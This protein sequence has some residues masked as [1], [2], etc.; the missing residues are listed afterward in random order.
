MLNEEQAEQSSTVAAYGGANAVTHLQAAALGARQF[1]GL[2]RLYPFDT[3]TPEGR[4]RERHRRVVLSAS[5]AAT[6]KF[7]SVATALISVP[8]T[9]HYLGPER[10][11]MWMTMSSLI[12]MFA[13][14]DLG[15]GHGILNVVA[16]A[17]GREDRNAI[18]EAASSGFFVL[19]I[20]AATILVLFAAAYPFVS[21]FEIF[22][23]KS[24][25]A[26]LEAGPA[27]A[28]AVLCFA[29][30]IP[31]GVVQRVQTGLQEGYAANLWRCLGSILG[32]IGVLAVI[33]LK[34]GLFW[35]VVAFLG[36]PL[37][38]SIMNSIA[39]F[40]TSEHD[41]APR[42]H[43]V[44][45]EMIERIARVGLL[46]FG[47]QIAMAVAFT[48]D[49][50]IIAQ[51]LGAEA[52]TDYAV[53]EKMFS[54]IAVIV[55]MVLFPLWPAYGEA[56]ARGDQNWVRQ[57]LL[58][59]LTAA[60]A[61]TTVL[62][63]ILVTFGARLIALWTGPVVDAPFML[64]VGLGLWRV[65][66]AGGNAV[67]MF[68]NG[69]NVVQFQLYMAALMATIAIVLKV[70]L[71]TYFGISGVV[72]ATIVANLATVPPTFWYVRRWLRER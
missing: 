57:T 5:A 13:F 61:T 37:V 14:A 66:E 10:Y 40:G 59:S 70:I 65:I 67:S 21:W 45:R 29:L 72:W 38:A 2:L 20:I 55:S 35:L 58:R 25:A 11:G 22:N 54:L 9:L 47:L 52:V 51:I 43:Y 48:S 56:I 24:E 17:S 32:L 23:V 1:V 19:T 8:L 30:G 39:F 69:A 33:W 44:S 49:N 62:S 34:W 63:L 6:A 42:R 27:L 15:M 18:R 60:I 12:V 41:L 3:S 68:L 31:L 16:D 53:P 71:V 26:R 46:F 7:V 50:I 64:L 28:G 36:G 4:S